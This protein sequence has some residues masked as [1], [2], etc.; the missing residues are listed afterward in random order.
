MV[1]R[2]RQDEARYHLLDGHVRVEMLRARG[3]TMVTCLDALEDEA[4][5]YNKRIS[6]VAT[7]QEHKMILNAVKEG[8]PEERLARALNVRRLRKEVDTPGCAMASS[9]MDLRNCLG[10]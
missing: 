6:A 3:D 8:V 10:L 2:D 5:T 7:I 1:I 9:L 4:F